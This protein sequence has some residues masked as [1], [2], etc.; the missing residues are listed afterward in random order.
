MCR[1]YSFPSDVEG[2]ET[3]NVDYI[4]KGLAQYSPPVNYLSKQKG[5]MHCGMEKPRTLTVRRYAARL[6]DIHD[7][8]DSFLGVTLTDN[9]VVTELNEIL[10]NSVNNNW[11][12]KV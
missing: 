2:T 3:I 4:I 6:I 5:A 9:I 11:Y 8:L 7:Y 12:R 1:F 10:L